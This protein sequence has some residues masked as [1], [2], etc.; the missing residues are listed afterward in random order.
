MVGQSGLQHADLAGRWMAA[1]GGGD[2]VQGSS[3]PDEMLH[4]LTELVGELDAAVHGHATAHRVAEV[5]A[6]LARECSV[7][8]E[9][10]GRSITVLSEYFLGSRPDD[11][12]RLELLG[13]FATGYVRALQT[14]LL[15]QQESIRDAEST[16]RRRAEERLRATEARMRAVFAQAGIGTG[17]VDTSGRLIEVNDAFARML[18]YT[19]EQMC[20]L[21]LSARTHPADPPGIRNLYESVSRGEREHAQLEKAYRH[22]DGHTVWTNINISLIRDDNGAPRYVLALV[23]DISERRALR[24]RLDYRANHDELT[25]L[26]NRSYFLDALATAFADPEAACGLCYLDLDHFKTVNDTFGHAVGDQVLVQAA[27]RL[28]DCTTGDQTVARMGGDEFVILVPHTCGEDQ[29]AKLADTVLDAFAEPFDI[30]GTRLSISASIGVME[31]RPEHTSADQLLNAAD[32]SMYWAKTGGRGRYAVFDPARGELEHTRAEL[33]AALPQALDRGEFFLDYQPILDL[34]TERT[35]AVEALVRWR[36]PDHGVLSPACF[37]ELA[38]DNGHIGALTEFV[39]EQACRDHSAN[40][41]AD[42][43]LVSVNISATDMAEHGWL[44]RVHAIIAAT[45]I[46]PTNLQLELTESAFMDTVRRPVRALHEL[47][48]RGVRLALDDFGTGYSNL[49]YLSRLP[50]HT[51]KLAGPFIDHI[52]TPRSIGAADLLILRKIIELAHGLGLTVTAECVE[53]RDQADR[54]RDLGCDTAQG[55][56][57]HRPMSIERLTDLL[58]EEQ[59]KNARTRATSTA[60]S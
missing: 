16:A 28:A 7:D 1:L 21:P 47:A 42:A 33:T 35:V 2:R 30:D 43:P 11:E 40:G 13:A 44:D 9:T 54:L 4:L 5:G 8:D 55:W 38:E 6:R 60:R 39:L 59:A 17:L 18:G 27:T 14:R 19:P 25:G 41:S 57:F 23:E 58:A 37:V 36:H 29:L 20:R 56:Y 15:N 26:P 22:R 45:G 32:T 24:E 34:A 50:L 52:G 3:D 12:D 46:E 53:T 49:A 48:D 10:L 51:I 31:R